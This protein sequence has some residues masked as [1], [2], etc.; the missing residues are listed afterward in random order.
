MLSPDRRYKFQLKSATRFV[1]LRREVLRR[2]YISF[3]FY[4][5]NESKMLPNALGTDFR[6][7]NNFHSTVE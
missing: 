6:I 4:H 7:I 5:I 3:S 2:T 1:L